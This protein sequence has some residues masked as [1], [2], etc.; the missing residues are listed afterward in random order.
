MKSLIYDE[1]IPTLDL[2][3]EELNSF[4]DAVLERFL[5]PYV[6][7]YLMSISL[8]A[9]SKF[10]TRDLPSLLQYVESK[11]QL[12]EKLVFSLSALI[13]FYKGRRGDEEIKLADDADIL[14]WFASLWGG[15][16]GT[17]SGLRALTAQVLAATNRWGCDLNEVAGLTD[18][19]AEGLIA[20]ERVGMKQA[21]QTF[22]KR[23]AHN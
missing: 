20:I 12:P 2:P 19:T 21:L 5:N 8:N 11:G 6:Q 1:I 10:K 16:D 4:A 3:A 7:H 23:P 22:V 13:A 14:E 15:W 9:I 18:K 17:D